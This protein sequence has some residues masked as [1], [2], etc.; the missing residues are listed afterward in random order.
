MISPP[1]F[2]T[3]IASGAASSSPRYLASILAPAGEFN[4]GTDLLR[5]CVLGGPK[6]IRNQP[7]REAIRNDVRHLLTQEF[8]AAISELLF[9]L[10]IQQR[11]HPT[12]VHHHHRIGSRFEHFLEFLLSFVALINR[13]PELVA[14]ALAPRELLPR[15]ATSDKNRDH[16]QHDD[17]SESDEIDR[18]QPNVG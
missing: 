18:E 16:R 11:D 8:I 7:F 17:E 5:Q 13:R 1:W 10:K 3:T 9:R 15:R 6:T 12:L 2:T 14:A 4:P